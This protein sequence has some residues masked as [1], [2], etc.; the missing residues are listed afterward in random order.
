MRIVSLSIAL[1]TLL[2]ATGCN[3]DKSPTA[4]SP[5]SAITLT[6]NMAFGNVTVGTTATSTLTI[7]N[8]GTAD[9]T[10]TSVTYPNG[11]T[12][13]FASG[14]APANGSQVVT[15]TFAPTAAQSYS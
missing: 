15:V 2:I 4:P 1:V 10:V 7:A 6:G 13:T 12:G 5:T 11:F 8:T 14:T 3:K 9:L